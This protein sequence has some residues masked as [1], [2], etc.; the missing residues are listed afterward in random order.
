[1]DGDGDGVMMK[2]A[3]QSVGADLM[4]FVFCFDSHGLRA[5][6][7]FVSGCLLVSFVG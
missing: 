2:D 5:L 1:M 3:F 6:R 7:C 4:I